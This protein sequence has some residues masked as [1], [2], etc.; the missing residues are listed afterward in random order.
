[1]HQ[2]LETCCHLPSLV[3]NLLDG[4]CVFVCVCV[5]VCVCV[6]CVCVCLITDECSVL[7]DLMTFNIILAEIATE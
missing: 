3:I 6:F 5:C 1:M 7:N 4:L 2:D